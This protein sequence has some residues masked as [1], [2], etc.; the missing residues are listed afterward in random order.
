MNMERGEEYYSEADADP[1]GNMEKADKEKADKEKAN[2]AN[3]EN[4]EVPLDESKREMRAEQGAEEESAERE[5]AGSPGLGRDAGSYSGFT[6]DSNT[7]STTGSGSSSVSS[8]SSS[9][10]SVTTTPE[11]DMSGKEGFFNYV[12]HIRPYVLI[13]TFVF[14]ASAFAG[15]AYS[16]STPEISEMVMEE[17]E[18]QFGG[19]LNLHPLLIMLIIFLNNAFVSLLF[20]VMGLGLGILPVLFVAF[21]GYVVGVLSHLVAEEQGLLFIFLALLPHGIIELPMVFLAAGIGLR[22]G[23][24]VLA[25]LIGRPTELKREFKDGIRFYFRWIVPLLFVAAV[26]ETFITPL[27]LGII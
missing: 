27:L 10:S 22:L 18:A 12:N 2:K 20:L 26:I 9:F 5:K 3:E 25:A 8:S 19:I 6:F 1:Q 14:F 13:I 15:Y 24:Q 17:F 16:A 21:N 4:A 7:G 23:H 11:R